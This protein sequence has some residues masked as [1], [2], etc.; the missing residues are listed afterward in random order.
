MARWFALI[1][2]LGS[3]SFAWGDDTEEAKVNHWAW[4][5]PVKP[6]VP[7]V[8]NGAWVRNP[9]D[10][11]ILAKLEAAGVEPAPSASREAWIR[12]VTF[13]LIGLPPTL[14]EID[15]FLADPSESA[16]E[17]VVDRLLASPQYG[18]RW[19]R[20]WLDLARYADSNGY[21]FDEVRPNAWRYRDYLIRSLNQDIPYDRFLREQIAG[22][23]WY[24]EV[25]DAHLA[26]GF[27]LLGPDMTDSSNQKQRRQ[28]MLDDMTDTA[29]LTFL[30]LTMGC[31]RCHNHKFEPISIRDYYRFQSFFASA[32][33]RTDVPV[34]DAATKSAYGQ[35]WEK[36]Q[37]KVR[38]IQ[39]EIDQLEAPYREKLV[40]ARILKLAE[41]ARQAH[42]TPEAK[43][44]PA[45]RELVISTQRF[46]NVSER[47]VLAAL[48]VSE[49]KTRERLSA[50]IKKLDTFK[51]TPLPTAMGLAESGRS[52]QTFVL[53]RGEL[54][55]LGDEVQPGF[56][57]ILTKSK[58][59]E[60]TAIHPKTISPGKNTTTGR[61]AVLAEWMTQPNH[62][63]TT[64]VIVNRL[65]YYHFGRGIVASPSDFGVRGERPTHPELLDYLATVF[66]EDGWSLKKMHR[67]ML[68]SA[69]YRQAAIPSDATLKADPANQ[70]FSRM[71]RLRLDGETI[72]D[73][74][75]AVSG[76][77]NPKAGG[78]GVLPPL[79]AELTK[80]VKEWKTSP[81]ASDHVRRSVYLQ[82]RRNLRFP[83]LEPFDPPDNNQSCPKRDRSTTA[84][85]ALALL[86][87]DEV[88]TAADALANLAKKNRLEN[89]ASIDFCF[90]RALGRSP[91]P[92]ELELAREFLRSS[93]LNELCRTLFNVNEFV[94]LD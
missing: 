16:W 40:A 2:L 17:S 15:A 26:T 90:R 32:D 50:E 74:L 8:R 24:P 88:K 20:H 71:N 19:A 27:N 84:P 49:R 23:E 77:L 82:V 91:R 80:G 86:N 87:A 34:G 28:N 57:A 13:D 43:R 55:N 12:R 3:T 61:R 89:D 59:E 62:P 78:P 64:R 63:L 35:Q 38:P 93:P 10:A 7:A 48:P 67:R 39:K 75:L 92:P 36:Y 1:L 45:Q 41:A 65:W 44:S 18:E 69:T 46:L 51:P 54:E 79:P 73:S 68:L 30:G 70:L 60:S 9:I 81:D 5:T 53:F 31:A 29:S 56:P 14:Q 76:R 37:Q 83:F 4:R 25:A 94:Y 85:Q 42:Q 33:F 11:F 66:V 22:D 58:Q 52:G 72:R 47:D 6:A 21:E